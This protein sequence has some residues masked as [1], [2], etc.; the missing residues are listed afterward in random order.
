M[1]KILSKMFSILKILLL[2]GA[3][4]LIFI[5]ILFTYKR[6]NKTVIDAIPIFLPFVLI[7]ILLI[8][9]IIIR[10]AKINEILIF[11][12][13]SCIMFAAIIY[14]GYR[15]KFDT[16][17]LLYYKYQINYNPSYL[18]DNISSIKVMLYALVA[19][20]VFYLLKSLF[21]EKK[22]A[23]NSNVD[24]KNQEEKILD[25]FVPNQIDNTDIIKNNTK[26]E[27]L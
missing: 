22:V 24:L 27:E 12:F 14:I 15:A 16:N 19:A 17:M 25:Q 21:V 3:F 7:F 9:N 13:T 8:V 18:S 6:L 5:G 10:K 1:T 11:N 20:N 4:S 2:L 26:V 23:L